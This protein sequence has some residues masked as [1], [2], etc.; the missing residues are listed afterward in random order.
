MKKI[1]TLFAAALLS[2]GAFAQTEWKDLVVNGNMEGEQ[3]PKW[4]SF[5]CHDWRRGL[6]DFDP[7]SEQQYDGGDP[8]NGQFQGFAE[9]VADPTDPNNHCARVI[10][11]SEAEADEAGNKVKNGDALAS[12]DCQFFVYSNEEIPV[13]KELRLTM[14][15]MAEKAWSVETQAHAKPGD[16]NHWQLF[17]NINIPAEWTKIQVTATISNDMVGGINEETGLPNKGM[18]S[19][20]FNLSTGKDGNVFY[21]DDIK[22]EMRDP[23]GPEEFT[24]WFN[25]LRH[26][27]QSDDQVGGGRTNF[28]G[29]DGYAYAKQADGSYASQDT[30]A[31]IVTDAD[32]EPALMVTSIGWTGQDV[33]KKEILDEE[34]NPVL[35]EEGNPTYEEEIVNYYDNAETGEHITSIDDWRTQFFVTIPHKF[36]PNSKYSLV[37]WARADKPATVQTQTHRLPGDYIYYVGVG[38]LN[39]TT[40]WQKFE[41]VDQTVSSDQSGNGSFQTMAFNCNVLKE[42]NNYYFRF[43]EFSANAADVTD[44]ERTLASEATMLPVPEPGTQQSATGTI[45][46][47]ACIDKLEANSFEN[48]VNENMTVQNGEETFGVTDPSAGFFLDDKGWLA[49]SETPITVEVQEPSNDNTKLEFYVYNDGESFAGKQLDT[50]FRFEFNN[51][52]Y[53]FNVNMVPETTYT[54]ISEVKSQPAQ[55]VVFDLSG[56]RV[57]QATKGLY[58]INGKKY[59]VK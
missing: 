51:W 32:G 18:Y 44:D 29:R 45:D 55:N 12:W 7:D 54:G 2:S 14:R 23:K 56:R 53:V 22:L 34:G 20:A 38:D 48:L 46:F 59:V 37:F 50:K 58:I 47:A 57:Q 15:A 27:T 31:R 39:L 36:T 8:E 17:G 26:G 42:V 43:E 52:F 4:S 25:M 21:F 30:Q 40:E 3:D 5:W 41:F 6:G 9:I 49:E 11:R 19:V 33:N 24:G 1:F 28:T 13:G 16:Y 10:V 35:D